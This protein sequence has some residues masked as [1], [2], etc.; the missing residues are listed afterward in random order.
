MIVGGDLN[1]SEDLYVKR[2]RDSIQTCF[3]LLKPKRWLSV[4]F[5]HWSTAYFDAILTGAAEAGGDLRAAISQIGDPVWSMH[6]KKGNQSVLAGE[7]ILT[8]LKTGK[9]KT[10]DAEK[11]FDVEAAIAR[12][13]A[14][15]P[16]RAVYGEYL[17][18][19]LVIEAWQSGTLGSLDIG[20]TGFS[21]MMER[22]GWSYDDRQHMWREAAE[23]LPLLHGT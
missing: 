1:L 14:G 19:R 5:Q 7:L 20:R 18:N 10:I 17:F 4:V 16:S 2:L 8:F 11:P 6:K 12:I 23:S 9:P 15:A 21:D 13:L 3:A 22:L